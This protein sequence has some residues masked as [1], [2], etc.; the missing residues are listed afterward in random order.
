MTLYRS[1]HAIAF[2][3]IPLFGY[4][5]IQ[6]APNAVE[7]FSHRWFISGTCLFLLISSFFIPTIKNNF[8]TITCWWL[9][10]D[11][12]WVTWTVYANNFEIVYYS[13]LVT[14]FCAMNITLRR[15]K[16][17]Y[18]FT[19]SSVML[20]VI[21]ALACPAPRISPPMIVFTMLTLGAA[22]ML[23]NLAILAFQKKLLL[24]NQELQK[25]VE[26][27]A[28]IAEKRA[29]QLADKNKELEQ[30]AYVAS[31]DL[32]SPLRNIGGFAQLLQRKLKDFSG[33][34]VHDYMDFIVGGVKR[35]DH[36]IEDILL[37]SRF[38]DES[39]KFK[40]E[41]IA[42]I[43][44]ETFSILRWEISE[45]QAIIYTDDVT[46][47]IICDRGQMIQLLQNL[48]TN[49]LKYNESEKPIIKITMTSVEDKFLFCIKDNGI[50]IPQEQQARV[51]KMFQRLHTDKEFSG[52]GI[53]LAICKRIVE[54]HYGTMS[55]LSNLGEGSK[56]YFTI[57][58][59]LEH[60]ESKPALIETQSKI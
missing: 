12:V 20:C 44:E 37:Y 36:V 53:G 15:P 43:L 9:F 56:F 2:F 49:A 17:F 57:S 50:G 24:Q 21:A 19:F 47:S 42:D 30:F 35:M 13:G 54:N 45:K 7:H 39:T 16:L 1:I 58:K 28:A 40:R 34:D 46:G 4:L 18:F 11:H 55:V 25:E 31:H 6:S 14:S 23:T 52:T 8:I 38:R 29:E 60:K 10:L 3:A 51:F 27:R 33:K 32:K 41:D 26:K 59:T 22:F 5:A 48:L